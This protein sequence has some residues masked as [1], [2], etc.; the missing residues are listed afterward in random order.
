MNCLP[1]HQLQRGPLNTHP[2]TLSPL[3][4]TLCHHL[5]GFLFC[6]SLSG[7]PHIRVLRAGT[8]SALLTRVSQLLEQNL[9]HSRCFYLLNRRVETA[10]SSQ[11][12][13]RSSSGV[14]HVLRK[15]AHSPFLSEGHKLSSHLPAGLSPLPISL[16]PLGPLCQAVGVSAVQDS[17][18][19]NP[20][21]PGSFLTPKSPVRSP[22]LLDTEAPKPLVY[23]GICPHPQPSRSTG[24]SPEKQPERRGYYSNYKHSLS[25]YYAPGTVQGSEHPARNK[26]NKIPALGE[27]TLVGKTEKS[28]K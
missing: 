20:I 6:C 4:L 9:A 28:N 3:T 7:S 18:P 13:L 17:S 27:L 10:N 12:G 5:S 23:H 21:N 22:E 16:S 8:L 15:E 14:V 26:T 2:I 1:P 11:R 24:Q 25:T 19:A